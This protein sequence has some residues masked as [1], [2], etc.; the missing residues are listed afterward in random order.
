MEAAAYN[1]MEAVVAD[2][3]VRLM[4]VAKAE[5]GNLALQQAAVTATRRLA[6]TVGYEGEDHRQSA[7]LAIK[8]AQKAA[9]DQAAEAAE[10]LKLA[11]VAVALWWKAKAQ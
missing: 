7:V 4:D 10:L 2:A 1:F 3:V 8:I 9:E 6:R 5:P 11:K